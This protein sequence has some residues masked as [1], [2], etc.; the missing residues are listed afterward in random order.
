MSRLK[1]ERIRIGG[2][3]R[4]PSQPNRVSKQELAASRAGTLGCFPS[5]ELYEPEELAAG[6]RH[7]PPKV[8]QYVVAHAKS[9]N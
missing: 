7:E 4:L 9:G 5:P 3:L 6:E 8:E 1:A 2:R